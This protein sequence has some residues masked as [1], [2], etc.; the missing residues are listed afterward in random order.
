MRAPPESLRPTIGAPI[1][2]ARSITLTILAALVSESDPP[3]TVKSC[4]KANVRRP[5]TRPNPATTPSPGTTWSAMPKSRQRW[6]TSASRSSKDPAS[7]SSSMR[8]PASSLPASRWRCT[9]N[10]TWSD[11]S[12]LVKSDQVS[13]LRALCLLP[14]LEEPFQ[15]DVGQRMLE[16]LLDHR[17]RR[18]HDIRAH[19]RRFDDVNR[20]ADAGDEHLGRVLEVV[21]DVDDLADQGHAGGADVVEPADERADVA[22]AHLGGQP[23][24]GRREDQR[25]VDGR[26][27]RRQRPARLDAI[28]G[29]GHLDDDVLVDGGEIAPL[30]QHARGVGGDDLGADRALHRL[31]DLLEDLPVVAGFLGHQRRVRRHAVENADRGERF[32]VLQV[33][34]VDE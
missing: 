25:D 12:I 7:N 8:S 15:P 32:D 6:V 4:A 18:G 1:F 26:A 11:F 5:L 16:A 31:A 10:E 21:E 17:G 20:M 29:E 28:L 27:L 24:L 33:A 22:G 19:P 9:R 34:G 2:T 30:A 14:V 13:D 23:G 3:K